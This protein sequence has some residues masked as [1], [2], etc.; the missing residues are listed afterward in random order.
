[1]EAIMPIDEDLLLTQNF[2]LSMENHFHLFFDTDKEDVRRIGVVSPTLVGS[3]PLAPAQQPLTSHFCT[4]FRKI[5][6]EI[7]HLEAII[8]YNLG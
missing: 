5:N 8:L 1:M 3:L 2:P 6:R 4:I 7:T